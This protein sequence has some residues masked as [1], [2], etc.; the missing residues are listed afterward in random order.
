MVSFH[1]KLI[2]LSCRYWP[3]IDDAL[4]AAAVDRHIQVRLLIS[5]WNHTRKEEQYFLRS[6][7]DISGSYHG[8]VI[9][10]VG[11]AYIVLCQSYNQLQA[12]LLRGNSLA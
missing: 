4:R 12:F 7:L 10:V 2:V 1:F 3:E 11:K 8:V 6:L 5:N 9:E